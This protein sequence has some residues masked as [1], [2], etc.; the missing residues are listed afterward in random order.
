MS[1]IPSTLGHISDHTMQNIWSQIPI[2][3]QRE[4][5]PRLL[6]MGYVLNHP[7]ALLLVQCTECGKSAIAQTV[8]IIDC[9]VT[10][11]IEEALALAVDQKSKFHAASNKYGPVLAYQLDSIKKPHLVTKLEHSYCS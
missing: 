9:G 5:I 1:L 11:V 7:Q 4:D 10:L 8:G 2:D 3:F 6:M